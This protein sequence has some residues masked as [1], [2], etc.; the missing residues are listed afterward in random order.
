MSEFVYFSSIF[1]PLS[2]IVCPPLFRIFISITHCARRV[3]PYFDFSDPRSS[4]ALTCAWVSWNV[5]KWKCHIFRF[6]DR[7]QCSCL[8]IGR[9]IIPN[10]SRIETVRRVFCE[11]CFSIT[12]P[13]VI[14]RKGPVSSGIPYFPFAYV[15][16]ERELVYDFGVSIIVRISPSY[17]VR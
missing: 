4:R 17:G 1:A 9:R 7:T 16:Y 3:A 8:T 6:F 5:V 12:K 13:D 11:T 15:R 2:G 10:C 14:I